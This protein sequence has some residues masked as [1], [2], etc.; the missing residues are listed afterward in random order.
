MVSEKERVVNSRP[1]PAKCAWNIG[2]MSDNNN[3]MKIWKR[4]A[5]VAALAALVLSGAQA[6]NA[7]S[8]SP[9]PTRLRVA[10]KDNLTILNWLDSPDVKGK[11]VAYRSAQ[12]A[13]KADNLDAA[14]RLGE[15]A[16]GV[17]TYAD[18]PPDSAPY[19]YGVF[20]L[21]DDGSPYQVFLP[22]KNC[23]AVAVSV[24][25]AAPPSAAKPTAAAPAVPAPPAAVKPAA[26]AGP[27]AASQ[28]FVSSLAAKARGDAIIVSYKAS[29]KSRLVLYR[30]TAQIL[31]AADLLDATL[32]A[33]F[34]D[35]D[36]TFADFPV[37][38]LDY[39]YAILGE[40]DL[41]AGRISLTADG[42]SLTRPVQVRAAAVSAGFA[43]TPP[44]SRTP[45][46]PYFLMEDKAFGSGNVALDEGPPP[47]RPVSP[48]TEKAI[49]ALLAKAP[50]AQPAMPS[51]SLLPE[52]LSAPSGGEDY[53]LSLIVSDRIAAKDW[54]GAQDQLRKY[55]SLNRGP[56]ASA[57]AR[58]YLGESLAF[59]GSAREAFFEFLSAR[60]F[61]PIETKPWIEYVLSRLQSDHG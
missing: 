61:Y 45:P 59:T 37:P 30:G 50:K 21:A 46:L 33:A 29:P 1:W 27:P 56:S 4:R 12:A 18:T 19:F 28:A 47:A 6:Q 35:K 39:Y 10:V 2:W 17:Q 11:Y 60:D 48:E 7:A 42:N 5:I 14:T 9:F 24:G 38:G 53:A 49:G 3:N 43:E 22:M 44:A 36:G 20:A 23:T 54:A 13:L 25:Q 58:F 15:I 41:K 55:L 26:P 32:V 57:R 16:T 40:E 51:T 8:F 34:T 31:G 52:E